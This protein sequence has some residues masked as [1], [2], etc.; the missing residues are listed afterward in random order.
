MGSV[1]Y[2]VWGIGEESRQPIRCLA[3]GNSIVERDVIPVVSTVTNPGLM[4]SVT[5]ARYNIA[6]PPVPP[7][8]ADHYA[9]FEWVDAPK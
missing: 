7:M 5:I 6:R 2:L 1:S 9:Q 3:V 4:N 8:S